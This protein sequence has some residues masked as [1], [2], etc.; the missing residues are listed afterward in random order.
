ME[1]KQVK[2]I[3]EAQ[4]PLLPTISLRPAGEDSPHS[5]VSLSPIGRVA[6]ARASMGDEQEKDKGLEEL[7]EALRDI[8]EAIRT[9][10]IALDYYVDEE[11]EDIV[12]RVIEKPSDRVIRQIPPESVLRIK[13][14]IKE[15]LGMIYDQNG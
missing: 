5:E 8:N 12:V 4:K 11:T 15:L 9:R 3:A 13:G 14:H 6:D 1:V 10:N 7:H 2:T